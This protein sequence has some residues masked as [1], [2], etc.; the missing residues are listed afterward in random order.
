MHVLALAVALIKYSA[1]LRKSH[2][3][4]IRRYLSWITSS[5]SLVGF[6]N[7]GRQSC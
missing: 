2:A 3:C 5:K 6:T 4:T 7:G 1:Q